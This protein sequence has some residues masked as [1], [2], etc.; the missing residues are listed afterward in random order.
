MG[1]KAQTKR[2]SGEQS[3]EIKSRINY[4]EPT[5]VNDQIRELG[6]GIVKSTWDDLLGASGSAVSEQLWGFGNSGNLQEGQEVNLKKKPQEK[7][8]EKATMTSEH[9]EYFRSV[10]NADSMPETRVE[11]E[12][13]NSVDQIRMEIKKLVQTSKIVE[14]TVKDATADKAPVRPGKYHISF[15]EFVLSVVRDATRKLE[16]SASYGAIFTSKKQQSKYWSSFKKQGT[17]FGL[18]G[19][20]TVATQT[21]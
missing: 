7:K 17:T 12:I 18:S 3:A 11:N 5:T 9:M 21:G 20:R 15:F 4:S 10:N 2:Q 13:R 6:K 8:E 16:D 19:E 14:K 1:S